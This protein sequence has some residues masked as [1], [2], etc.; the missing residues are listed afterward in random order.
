MKRTGSVKM[1]DGKKFIKGKQASHADL[2]YVEGDKA[3]EPA[4]DPEE[5]D[6]VGVGVEV[7]DVAD[8]T[9]ATDE[10]KVPQ[11]DAV[12]SETEAEK[13]DSNTGEVVQGQVARQR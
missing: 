13:N 11:E 6:G 4:Q 10:N 8:V 12:K 3:S 1:G 2:L 7:T 9:D 5:K